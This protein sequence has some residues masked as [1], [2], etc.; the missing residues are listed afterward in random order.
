[1]SN[2]RGKA[3]TQYLNKQVYNIYSQI[4]YLRCER[5]ILSPHPTPQPK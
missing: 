3:Y 4:F 2:I 1:M 5:Y